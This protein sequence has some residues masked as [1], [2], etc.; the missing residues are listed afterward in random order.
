MH[1][2]AINANNSV[3]CTVLI[4]M[5]CMCNSCWVELLQHGPWRTKIYGW[6]FKIN[7]KGFREPL[8]NEHI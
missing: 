6:G 2:F 7:E 1:R 5:L 3:H 4:I 8:Q